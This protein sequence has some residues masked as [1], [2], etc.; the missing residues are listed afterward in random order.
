M[1]AVSSNISTLQNQIDTVLAAD[2]QNR[3]LIPA[4]LTL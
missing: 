4:E 3:R 2:A 1:L